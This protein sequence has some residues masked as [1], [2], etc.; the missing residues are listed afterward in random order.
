MTGEGRAAPRWRAVACSCCLSA[1]ALVV[2][3]AASACGSASAPQP[4]PPVPL[5]RHFRS[6]ALGVAFR[7]PASWRLQPVAPGDRSSGGALVSGPTGSIAVLV[8]YSR[9]YA[10]GG[11]PHA[12]GFAPAGPADLRSLSGAA[13]ATP[14]HSGYRRV[15]GLRLASVEFVSAAPAAVAQASGLASAHDLW[16]ASARPSAVHSYV[17]I[18]V[19][20][21]PTRWS[22]DEA[23]L[24]AVLDSVRL[25]RPAGS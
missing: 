18:A 10:V 24:L 20:C 12:G 4:S 21:P 14:L 11:A 17:R 7:Y 5:A 6:A 8:Y 15:S 16:C 9:D 13:M 23:T 2:L 19:Y 1:F 22:A 3:V 25:S